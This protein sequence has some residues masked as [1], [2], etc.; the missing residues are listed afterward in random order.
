SQDWEVV[1]V[2]GP[3]SE[4]TVWVFMG[5]GARLPS[6]VFASKEAAEAWIHLNQLDGLLTEY[7]V[8]K[9]AYD[10]AVENGHFK[11]VKPEQRTS[12]F[13]GSFTSAALRHEHYE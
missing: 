2:H 6:A 12:R 9:S 10:W 8:D 3:V 5:A 13:I 11:P 1:M 4:A 7:P